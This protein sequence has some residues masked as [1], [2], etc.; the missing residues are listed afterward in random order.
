MKKN[1]KRKKTMELHKLNNDLPRHC[2]EEDFVRINVNGLTYETFKRTLSRFPN[3]LLG[4]VDRRQQYYIPAKDAYFFERDQTSFQAILYYYQSDGL[5]IRPKSVPLNKFYEEIQFFELG[6]DAL[7]IFFKSEGIFDETPNQ[8]YKRQGDWR[9]KIWDVLEFTDTSIVARIVAMWSLLIILLSIVICILE[10]VPALQAPPDK[11]N[12][13]TFFNTSLINDSATRKGNYNASY[14]GANDVSYDGN[15]NNSSNP[16]NDHEH[17][18]DHWFIME[19][20]CVTWFTLEYVIRFCLAPN[21]FL[22]M[23]SFLNVID[24]AAIMPYYLLLCIHT[25][26]STPI[27]ILRLIRVLRVFRLFKLYRHSFCL[28]V[29]CHTVWASISELIM[30]IFYLATGIILFSSGMYY[31]EYK[32]N[33]VFSSIPTTF[34]YTVVTMSTLGYGDM[35]PMTF[36]GKVIG[37]A[38]ALSGVLTVGMVCPIIAS[39]FEFYHKRSV[40]C[41]KIKLKEGCVFDNQ[42]QRFSVG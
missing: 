9:Q 21:K 33:P 14:N 25:K 3:T 8:V 18:M 40:A 24:L 26:F 29:L 13:T 12:I 31:V 6:N 15:N 16:E 35:V 30:L 39:N 28:Q 10:T 4:N 20:F 17:R 23:K 32:V 7:S 27:P 19:L 36:L 5:L 11:K 2:D 42:K 1:D 38:C 41:N 37:G 34:W 22:F